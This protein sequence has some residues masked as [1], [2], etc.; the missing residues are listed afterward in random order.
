MTKLEET[1]ATGRR[2]SAVASVRIRQKGTGK[3]L[4]NGR[5][6]DKYF[7]QPTD[8][9]TALSPFDVCS[10][11]CKAFDLIITAKGGG[12]KAQAEAVRHGIARALESEDE[13]RRKTLKDEGFLT[14]DSRRKERKKCGQPK[15]RKKFQFSKR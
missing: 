10:V 2:K 4:V 13:Q 8:Q 11:D 1:I 14:R 5:E 9:T 6:F 15:A 7:S 12:V 3:H